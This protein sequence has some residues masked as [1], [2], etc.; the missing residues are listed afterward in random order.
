MELKI[1]Y[2]CARIKKHA[3]SDIYLQ[4]VIRVKCKISKVEQKMRN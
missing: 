3:K 1:Y 2:V 4:Y